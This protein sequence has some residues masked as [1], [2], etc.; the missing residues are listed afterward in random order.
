MKIKLVTNTSVSA[1]DLDTY[2]EKI[3]TDKFSK[4]PM[5]TALDVGMNLRIITIRLGDEITLVNPMISEKSED[6]VVYSE[7]DTIKNKLRKTKRYSRILVTSDNL[8]PIEFKAD[9]E[10][11]KAYDD[12]GLFNCVMVQRLIDAIDGIDIKHTSR[13]YN[14][15]LISDKKIGRNERVLVQSQEGVTKYVKY[16]HSQSYIDNGYK[17]I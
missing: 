11:T 5:L 15:Q 17:I 13:A 1:R 12:V 6:L 7:Y 8:P 14:T 10:L 3:H 9:G 16:K 4:L 2:L